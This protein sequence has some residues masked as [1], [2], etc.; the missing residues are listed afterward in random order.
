VSLSGETKRALLALARQTL[1][2]ALSGGPAP[3]LD[4]AAQREA[5]AKAGV[6][7]SLHERGGEHDLRGCI[8]TFSFDVPLEENVRKMAVAAG[9]QDP[10]F[11]PVEGPELANLAF[12][13]SVLTPPVPIAAAD[14]VV[15]THG[16]MVTRGFYRGVLL[17]QVPVDWQWSREEFLTQTCRKAGLPSD[18][19][20]QPGTVL[21]A[22]TADVFAE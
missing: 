20:Q 22:F 19:W 3:A 5:Q 4:P 14:V 17:P 21:E 7:V 1:Q 13:I 18:A 10:R 6:F 11:P 8:G 16:L 12:E 9:T 15:G 2:A